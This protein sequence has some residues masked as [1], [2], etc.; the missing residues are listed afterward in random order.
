M[1][2]WYKVSDKACMVSGAVS[3]STTIQRQLVNIYYR[4]NIPFYN[5]NGLVKLGFMDSLL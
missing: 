1:N 2:V 3:W 4:I 5:M